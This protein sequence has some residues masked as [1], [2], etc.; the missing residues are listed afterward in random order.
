VVVLKTA[1]GGLRETLVVGIVSDCAGR[2]CVGSDVAGTDSVATEDAEV[3]AVT[4]GV[5]LVPVS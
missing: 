1:G 3:F 5:E 2:G 4:T